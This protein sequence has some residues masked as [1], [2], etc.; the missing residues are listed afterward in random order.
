SMEASSSKEQS[1]QSSPQPP[2]SPRDLKGYT[3]TAGQINEVSGT[4]RIAKKREYRLKQE[5]NN[6][7][8]EALDKV[9]DKG[10]EKLVQSMAEMDAVLEMQRDARH[11]LRFFEVSEPRLKD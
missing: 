2:S 11:D 3:I 6:K 9:S 7:V 5:R 1:D 10:S 8:K 4:G